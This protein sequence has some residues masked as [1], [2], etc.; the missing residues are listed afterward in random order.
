MKKYWLLI[1]AP[2][3][4]PLLPYGQ[5]INT[6]NHR[7]AGAV[8]C[9]TCVLDSLSVSPS[10]AYS[11][12]KLRAAYAGSA[13]Q[14]IR[15]S[16][17]TTSDIGFTPT[18]ALDASTLGSF[19][20]A[21]NCFVTIWYDQSSSGV[22][23]VQP[24]STYRPFLVSGGTIQTVNGKPSI[25]ANDAGTQSVQLCLSSCSTNITLLPRFVNAVEGA[26][27]QGC[28]GSRSTYPTIIRQN[29]TT[30]GSEW[31]L[32]FNNVTSCHYEF[33]SLPS[34]NSVTGGGPDSAYHT[35]SGDASGA[36]LYVDGSNVASNSAW[37]TTST[38]GLA[39][40]FSDPA[41]AP[42][43]EPFKGYV[44]EVILFGVDVGSTDRGTLQ[45]NQKA[46][47]STP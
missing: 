7:K 15:S 26:P 20:A 34:Y 8:G 29:R 46:Y 14:V 30:S 47:Y 31:A 9:A 44:G 37:G 1:F 4:L 16:D 3:L 23:A 27:T 10:L 5:I 32:R 12:R 45:T 18:G 2:L 25:N 11:L 17:S 38:V 24:T 13:V 22:N 21:T 28:P 42:P 40:L 43:T 6:G 33:Y 39:A 35:V 19:C 41:S 36:I